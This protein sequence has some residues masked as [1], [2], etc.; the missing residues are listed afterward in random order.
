MKTT[1]IHS[2]L[3]AAVIVGAVS[4]LSPAQDSELKR[5]RA[6]F[7]LRFFEPEPHMALAKYFFDHSDRLQAFYILEAGR[8]S[9]LEEKV[10]NQAF[11]LTFRGFDYGPDAERSLLKELAANPQ[12]ETVNFKLA[13]LYIARD[14]LAKAKPYLIAASKIQP[15]DFKYV[16]GLAEIL[17]IEGHGQ[18]GDQL[19]KEFLRK[20][21]DSEEAWITRIEE[22]IDKNPAL[23]KSLL[24][25][26]RA[27]FPKS[28]GLA[29]ASARIFQRE[30]KLDE[31]EKILVEAAQQ[32]PES[33]N[34]QAWTGRFFLKVRG[35]KTKALDYYLNAYFLD[36]ETYDGEFAESRIRSL[37]WD[38]AQTE[39]E[40]RNQSG[41]PVEE[42][43][44]DKNPV[45]VDQ[46]LQQMSKTWKASYLNA[47]LTCLDH[48]DEEVRWIATQLIKS[49]VDRS[50]DPTL[51]ALLNDEDPRK[52]GLAAYL[53]VHLWKRD[54]FEIIK[55]M[56]T[57]DSEL[58]RFDAISALI[59]EG[60][61][62]GRR[63]AL[64]YAA[65]EKHPILKQL[66]EKAKQPQP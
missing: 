25:Q 15:D 31:A 44:S 17:K 40:K 51:K 16:V 52:R 38:L 13:D 8:R 11:Q 14:E 58:L 33:A 21:P 29:F 22:S 59:L 55:N 19:T 42:L 28:G 35:S 12:S 1:R 39:V 65:N 53:A 63:I 41:V 10:F 3:I 57:E 46:A 47:M 36:T 27:K 20:H 56:L 37:N 48:D 62:E 45:V 60:G 26:A 66:L 30:G 4:V 64:E 5:L 18:G 54:S 49:H 50:F 9:F 24:A 23:A 7:A 32:S 6:D 43:L 2:W 61:E 34:I